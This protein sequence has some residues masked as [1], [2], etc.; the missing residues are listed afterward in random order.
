MR[1]IALAL[2]AIACAAGVIALAIS[3]QY[4]YSAMCASLLAIAACVYKYERGAAIEYMV[5]LAVLSATAAVS[6]IAFAALPNIT[7]S[8]FIVIIS[9]WAMGGGAGMLVGIISAVTS[10]ITLGQGMWT[11]FQIIGWGLMGLGAGVIPNKNK[12][13]LAIY[14]AVSAMVFGAIMNLQWYVISG[15]ELGLPAYIAALAASL[16][17]DI[18][19]AA[20]NVTLLLTAGAPFARIIRRVLKKY[21]LERR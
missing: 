11:L 13:V 14:G 19:H 17:M 18:A 3:R 15:E 5:L 16:P 10:N 21:N 20:T 1:K 2:I 7:P 4:A 6:R 12:Y 9:G 8:S